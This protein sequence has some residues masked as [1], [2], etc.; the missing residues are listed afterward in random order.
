MKALYLIAAATLVL[1]PSLWAKDKDH[2]A[3]PKHGGVTAE[4]GKYHLELVAKD[5]SL[6][7]YAY[8]HDDKPLDAAQAKAQA[9]VFS[10]KDK[11]SLA[12]TPAGG[13]VMKGEAGFAIRS[14][15]K[16]VLTFTPA[17]GKAEQA[18]F[19]FGA[20]PDHKGHKH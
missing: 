20:K 7:L 16:I 1:A 18:R 12:L 3:E 4:A 2:H 6:T 8:G 15:A 17:G 9:N 13:N 5:K 19:Q 11:G 14:D 10:G